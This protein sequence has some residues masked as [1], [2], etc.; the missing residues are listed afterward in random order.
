M[1]MYTQ[2]LSIY[3]RFTEKNYENRNSRNTYYEPINN[4]LN[5]WSYKTIC[6]CELNF[7][8]KKST[9]NHITVVALFKQK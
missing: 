1:V 3:A 4:N 9:R 6:F 7:R 8:E 5:K 2:H